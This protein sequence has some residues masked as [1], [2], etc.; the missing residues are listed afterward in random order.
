LFYLNFPGLFG[1]AAGRRQDRRR[2][3]GR[4]DLGELA[5]LRL[6]QPERD[7]CVAGIL[8]VG[9]P[10]WQ[11]SSTASSRSLRL[12][13]AGGGHDARD[14]FDLERARWHQR[15]PCPGLEGVE[16][17]RI[18]VVERGWLPEA[19]TGGRPGAPRSRR[20]RRPCFGAFLAVRALPV[21]VRR[22]TSARALTVLSS[23][24]LAGVL[25]GVAGLVVRGGLGERRIPTRAC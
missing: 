9:A 12:A 11:P 1:R 16:L 4:G 3:V 7:L 19:T 8:A 6:E 5:R 13:P 24:M 18:L 21:A 17:A 22:L 20:A 23:L 10:R 15:R 25:S 14:Q 2:G